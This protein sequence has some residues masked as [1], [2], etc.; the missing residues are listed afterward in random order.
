MDLSLGH[1]VPI[2]LAPAEDIGGPF[3]SDKKIFKT[4]Q[5]AVGLILTPV[6]SILESLMDQDPLISVRLLL[7]IL[8][9]GGHLH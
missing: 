3:V 9:V 7:V 5:K 2:F 6:E 4:P 1:Y 8:M